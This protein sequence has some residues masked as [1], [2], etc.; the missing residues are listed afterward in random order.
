MSFTHTQ[1]HTYSENI[2]L[3]QPFIQL[4]IATGEQTGMFAADICYRTGAAYR[5]VQVI[6]TPLEKIKQIHRETT[7]ND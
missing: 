5:G 4:E 6:W 3:I 7:R 2:Q 1:T